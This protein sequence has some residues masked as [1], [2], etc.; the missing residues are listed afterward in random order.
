[1]QRSTSGCPLLVTVAC[2]LT[3]T[4]LFSGCS[5][6][7]DLAAAQQFQQAESDF[8]DAQSAEEFARVAAQYDRIIDDGIVSGVALYNRGNAWMRAGEAGLAIASWRQ[9]QRYRPRD[10]YLA[11]NLQSALTACQSTASVAPDHGVAGYIFFWQDWLSYPEKFALTTGLLLAACSCGLV[12]QLWISRRL[13]RRI[14]G[15]LMVL[16]LVMAVSAVWDWV[17]FE[18]TV[19]GVITVETAEARKGN[20]DSYE[21]AFT[22]PLHEGTEF[23]VLEERAGWLNIDIEGL[24]TAW[25]PSDAA[26]TW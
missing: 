19:R 17:R 10:P 25:I 26:V 23:T 4:G 13:L 9:A 11:A 1:M 15:L 7:P 8:A 16:F 18:Q 6:A 2:L 24:G 5:R 12:N 21:T 22:R 20:A 14:A 3:V